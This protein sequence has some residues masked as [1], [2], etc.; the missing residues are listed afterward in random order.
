MKRYIV[1]FALL[2]IS[3]SALVGCG[4]VRRSVRTTAEA[5]EF[6]YGEMPISEI[7]AWAGITPLHTQGSRLGSYIP[8]WYTYEYNLADGELYVLREIGKD[9]VYRARLFKIEKK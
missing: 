1:L 2:V 4:T 8:S 3:A 6:I 5:R 7:T 9:K